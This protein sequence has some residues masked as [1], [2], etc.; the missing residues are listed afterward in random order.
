MTNKSYLGMI[1][2]SKLVQL[3]SQVI[4]DGAEVVSTSNEVR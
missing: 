3:S 1:K 4:D 2:E